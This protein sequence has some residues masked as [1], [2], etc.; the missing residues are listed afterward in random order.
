[1]MKLQMTLGIS[2]CLV[3]RQHKIEKPQNH[4]CDEVHAG[5]CQRDLAGAVIR[6]WGGSVENV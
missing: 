6:D 4:P 5:G 3:D 2:Q 1:M